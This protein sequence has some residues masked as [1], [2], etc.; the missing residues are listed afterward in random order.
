MNDAGDISPL[1]DGP[2]GKPARML[3]VAGTVIVI[4]LA[5]LI[6]QSAVHWRDNVVD[7]HLF[8]YHGWCVSQGASPYLD[9][10]DNKPPGI[11]WLNAAGFCLCGEGIGAELLICTLALILTLLAFVGIVRTIYHPSLTLPAALIVA[12]L[13]THLSYE[14]GSNRTETF[15]VAAEMLAILGYLRWWRGKRVGWLVVGGLAAGIAPF[16]KQSGLAAAV[17]CGLH[18]VWSQVSGRTA[19]PHRPAWKP[20]LI[21]GVSFAVAPAVV[22][23][24]LASQGALSEA[25]F[26]VGPFNR[27][28]FAIDDATYL[29]LDRALKIYAPIIWS[30]RWPIAGAGIGLGWALW[31]GW[32]RDRT[33][34]KSLPTG[35]LLLWL[36][37]LLAVY[38]ACVGPGRRGHHFM[39]VL[40]ALGLLA[41][42]PLHRLVGQ[43]GL[44]VR[45]TGRP[46]VAIVLVLY[47]YGLG[48]LALPN[49]AELKR[50]WQRKS[51]I[52]S[53]DYGEPQG[54][55]VQA[56][57]I[58]KWSQPG[59]TI[60]V[61]GWSPGT[62]RYA[63]RPCVSRFATFEKVGQ[64]RQHAQFIIDSALE[65][66]YA[67]PPTVFVIS[68]NDLHGV[69]ADADDT[70]ARWLNVHYDN[71]GVIGGMY[72]LVRRAPAT[73]ESAA[74]ITG[75]IR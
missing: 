72:I 23:L 15:V 35:V 64:L 57:A 66:L 56:Q 38:L 22:T 75:P 13:L 8:A 59:E 65:D 1:A 31:R 69:Q 33:A 9:I 27:A 30:L 45:L 18:L 51:H 40:P 73:A 24:V 20:W 26:A 25:W 29:D 60:Y 62:Y 55:Q 67:R 58:R 71:R 4:V 16:F 34:P 41:L 37:G 52:F 47:A 3:L 48:Q 32:A 12:V 49:V 7:S 21:A 17:A 70:L 2:H 10:W 42:Y 5:V 36:W 39:P 53:L 44:A 50:C 61:W 11:W 74:R 43:S 6:N 46:T 28:Y 63:Y 19:A 14:C 68:E 54:Y